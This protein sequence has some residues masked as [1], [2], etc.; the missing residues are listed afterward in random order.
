MD[1]RKNLN[2]EDFNDIKCSAC[3]RVGQVVFDEDDEETCLIC[4]CGEV[5]LNGGDLDMI[6]DENEYDEDE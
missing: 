3:G 5:L 6:R 1:L 4:K 2:E